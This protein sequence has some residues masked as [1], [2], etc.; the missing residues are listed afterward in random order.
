[1]FR[2]SK[3]K[4]KKYGYIILLLLI[5]YS[6]KKDVSVSEKRITAIAF[7]S[8]GSQWRPDWSIFN[9][10]LDKKP[11]LYIALG[12]NMY[13]D[14]E[15]LEDQPFYPFFVDF[16]YQVLGQ[17]KIFGKFKKQV[18]IIATWDDHDY[19]KNNGGNE[20]LYKQEAKNAFMKFWN[21][22]SDNDMRSREGVYSAYYYGEGNQ[23]IQILMLDTRW[24]L[25]VISDEPIAAT[26]DASKKI[27][28]EPEWLW[29]EEE[30]KKPAAIRIIGSSTQFCTEHNGYEAWAN[31][32]LEMERF[33]STIRKTKAEGVFFISGDVHYAEI[34]KRK[35][36][37]LY[38]IYDATSSGLTHMEDPAK[39]SIY[40]IGDPYTNLNFGMLRID[41]DANPI[42]IKQ[43]IYSQSGDLVLSH[44]IL[45]NELKF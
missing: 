37:G 27:L 33:Y 24:F 6:C 10:I 35:V 42:S 40:R 13:A 26:T 9:S 3:L 31:Y 17:N 41:W 23:R 15:G 29:L 5:S 1:M 18:P 28:G 2:Y 34:N 22:S 45:L 38:P 16:G 44:Q 11:D 39:P 30:L 19:G 43:E 8:C 14:V 20:F 25:D 4:Y 32:P 12:D 7:G 36:E 21:V